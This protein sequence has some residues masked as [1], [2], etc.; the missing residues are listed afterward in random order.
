M[1]LIL[2][3]IFF[4]CANLASKIEISIGLDSALS[5]ITFQES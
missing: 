4:P 1:F 5:L 3:F 2:K